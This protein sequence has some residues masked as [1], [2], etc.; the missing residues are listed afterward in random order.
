LCMGAI[1]LQLLGRCG[2]LMKHRCM[3]DRSKLLVT[4]SKI[5]TTT[6]AAQWRNCSAC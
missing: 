5:V 3:L 2:K 1:L 6:C 4:G